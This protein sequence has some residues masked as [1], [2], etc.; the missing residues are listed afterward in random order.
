MAVNYDLTQSV[1]SYTSTYGISANFTVMSYYEEVWNDMMNY[2]GNEYGVAG[3]LGNMQAESYVCPFI[4]QGDTPPSQKSVDY[5]KSIDNGYVSESDFYNYK[6]NGGGYGLCQWTWWT[7]K[8]AL[9]RAWKNGH[10]DSISNLTLQTSFLWSELTGTVGYNDYATIGE[11][12]KNATSIMQ[13]SNIM[14]KEFENP[15]NQGTDVQQLR[16]TYGEYYYQLMH[17]SQP[18]P[19]PEPPSGDDIAISPTSVVIDIGGSFTVRASSSDEWS[20]TYSDNIS[21]YSQLGDVGTF[22]GLSAGDGYITATTRSGKTDTCIV[23]VIATPLPPVEKRKKW[24][25]YDKNIL[26]KK[27]VIL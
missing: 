7:R 19:E 25:Y 8:Q 6:I 15:K 13:A 21:L 9:Y 20:F 4:K 10:Y 5:T 17:G 24:L 11:R 18:P 23:H 12:L 22:V 1:V 14:L 2:I 26:I 3:V 27:G 16:A